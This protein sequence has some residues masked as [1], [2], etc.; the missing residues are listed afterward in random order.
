MSDLSRT[1]LTPVEIQQKLE[2]LMDQYQ[3]HMALHK[4]KTRKGVLETVVVSSAELVENIAKLK[5]SEVAKKLFSFRERRLSLLE[6]ELTAP[7]R[8]VAYIVDARER[9]GG[10]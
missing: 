4:M 9:F 7:G 5:L 10:E 2:Y 8:E 1:D 3:K 6:T